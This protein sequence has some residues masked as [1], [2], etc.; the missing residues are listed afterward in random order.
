MDEPL[1]TQQK[2]TIAKTLGY[3][4][5]V[6]VS[7]STRADYKL[8]YFTPKEEVDLCGHATIGTFVILK[9]LDQLTHNEYTIDTNVGCLKI[10]LQDD[11]IYME[12]ALPQFYDTIDPTIL[13]KCF[14]TEEIDPVYP[15]QIVS[16]GLKDILI[17]IHTE[18]ALQSLNP[19]FKAIAEI[20][21]Q[22][23][24][25]GMH[26]YAFNDERIVCRN[27]APF[28][29]IDEE[30]ATGTSNG[31]LACYLYAQHNIY[32]TPY[33]FEQGESLGSPSEIFVQLVI[34]EAQRIQRV[35]VG[36]RGYYT[37]TVSVN[38]D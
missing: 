14:N 19:D 4:E 24:V 31:A 12:Q 2:M 29:D 10:T 20:S 25:I 13:N 16:T 34:N 38:I 35:Y 6:F 21:Q 36:G 32:K 5:T 1:T 22:Y 9:Y 37:G 15:I 3:S 26:L 33:I 27:F 30:A 11:L 23:D 8:E 7:S 18:D 28:Y 17:P